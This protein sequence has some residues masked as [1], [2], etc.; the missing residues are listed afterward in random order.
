MTLK[1]PAYPYAG[2]L[3][4]QLGKL[5]MYKMNIKGLMIEACGTPLVTSDVSCHAAWM[6]FWWVTLSKAL[7]KLIYRARISSCFLS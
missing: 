6:S 1:S 2:V 3:S 7:R 5:L 4:T